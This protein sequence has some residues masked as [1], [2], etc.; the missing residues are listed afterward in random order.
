M[1]PPWSPLTLLRIGSVSRLAPDLAS[2]GGELRWVLA[3]A[4]GPQHPA[5]AAPA[6]GAHA[7]DLALRLG[8]AGRIAGRTPPVALEQE[9]GRAGVHG[10]TIERLRLLGTNR[11]LHDA[12][13]RVSDVAL[14]LG[15]KPLWLKFAALSARGFVAAGS[16]EARDVDLLVSESDGPVL[17]AALVAAGFKAVPGRSA[18]HQL[19]ALL[20]ESG[21]AVEIH[22]FVRGLRLAP[23]STDATLE[24]FLNHAAFVELPDGTLAPRDELLAAHALVHGFVQHRSRPKEYAPL[25]ALADLVALQA[26]NSSATQIHAFIA[27]HLSEAE[28]ASACELANALHQGTRIEDFGEQQLALLKSMLAASLDADFQSALGVERVVELFRDGGF[29][30]AV[31]RTFEARAEPTESDAAGYPLGSGVLAEPLE[32]ARQLVEGCAG[33]LRLAWRSSRARR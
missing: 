2:Y 24:D 9:L 18:A 13:R 21:A 33:Y 5:P 1:S 19:P 10:V 17:H 15:T 28:V 30:A 14:R 7:L 23:R 26:W 32:R 29:V 25:R 22:R 31:A 8:L 12:V 27:A 4:F 16:R 20:A 3:R 6:R 11:E